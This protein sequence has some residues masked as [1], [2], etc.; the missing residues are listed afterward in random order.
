VQVLM[1][2]IKVE[3]YVQD[4]LLRFKYMVYG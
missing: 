1:L 3:L 4:L 2:I